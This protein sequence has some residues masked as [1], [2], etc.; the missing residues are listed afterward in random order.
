MASIA[1]WPAD[2]EERVAKYNAVVDWDPVNDVGVLWSGEAYTG[3]GVSNDLHVI[4][5][6]PMPDQERYALVHV[7]NFDDVIPALYN[8]PRH[9]RHNGR[10]I[11]GAFYTLSLDNTTPVLDDDGNY[12]VSVDLWRYDLTGSDDPSK[13]VPMAPLVYEVPDD[14]G[15][16]GM[17]YPCVTADTQNNLLLVYLALPPPNNLFAYLVD[18]DQ[19]VPVDAGGA[20]GYRALAA[21]DYSP[22][23]AVHAYQDGLTNRENKGWGTV[24]V[25][26][27]E[28]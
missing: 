5:P 28:E 26:R 18:L 17:Y 24:V 6:N 7:G 14:S 9:G 2:P 16:F 25:T 13:L 10:I 1:G 27:S 20:A 23:H 3:G 4:R 11:G 19:W 21:C 12:Q 22:D 15:S 8:G